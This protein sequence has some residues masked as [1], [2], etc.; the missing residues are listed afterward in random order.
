MTQH[1]ITVDQWNQLPDEGKE[2][3]RIWSV[4]QGYGLEIV[5][6]ATESFDPSCDYA[7]LLDKAQL[8]E[9][10]N[11]FGIDISEKDRTLDALWEKV[12]SLATQDKA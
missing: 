10:I 12:V 11:Q 9:Y 4:A 5:P 2:K 6:S 7:A 1:K 8:S 3:L